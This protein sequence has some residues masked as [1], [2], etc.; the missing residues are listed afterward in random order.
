MVSGHHLL[1]IF[2]VKPLYKGKLNFKITP[3][4]ISEDQYFFK[5][6]ICVCNC[7][8]YYRYGQRHYVMLI[9]MGM[10]FQMD[11]NLV[12]QL[13]NGPEITLYWYPIILLLIQVILINGLIGV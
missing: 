1:V 9:Q 4:V 13:V 10:E 7:T 6:C 2:S 5:S 3:E 12:I 8:L 11:K